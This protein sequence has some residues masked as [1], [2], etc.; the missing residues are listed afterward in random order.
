MQHAF[1]WPLKGNC[2]SR[3]WMANELTEAAATAY[4]DIFDN[5]HGMRDDLVGFWTKSAEFWKDEPGV[6]GFE[7]IN[8]P[9]AGNVYKDPLLFLPAV[10]GSLNLQVRIICW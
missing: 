1:P 2:S 10:A 4:Q 9:F 5:N 3:N 8:E 6:V 7:L